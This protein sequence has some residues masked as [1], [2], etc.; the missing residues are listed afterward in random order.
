MHMKGR[1]YIRLE[2]LGTSDASKFNFAKVEN[3]SI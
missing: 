3:V 2:A 1:T